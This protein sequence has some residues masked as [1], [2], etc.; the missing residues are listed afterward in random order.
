ML[1]VW[2]GDRGE[3][4]VACPSDS[5]ARRAVFVKDAHQVRSDL[6]RS[7]TLQLIARN[8]MDQFTVLVERHG[9]RGRRDVAEALAQ[10]RRRFN[11]STGEHGRKFVGSDRRA[12]QGEGDARTRF[13]RRATANGIDHHKIRS[14]LRIHGGINLFRRPELGETD[15]G[16]FISER[17]NHYR[18]IAHHVIPDSKLIDE[19]IHSSL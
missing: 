10:T 7:P 17:L 14:F 1:G 3:H 6:F 9:R 4:V 11:V 5:Y 16:K 2:Q 8:K 12:T 13:P 15:S 19:D 18:V